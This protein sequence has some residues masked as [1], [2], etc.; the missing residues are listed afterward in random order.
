MLDMIDPVE[1]RIQN[2]SI[3]TYP[4]MST[5]HGTVHVAPSNEVGRFIP[6]LGASLPPS[7]WMCVRGVEKVGGSL[8]SVNLV[9]TSLSIARCVL[10]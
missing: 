4:H 10:C 3:H 8:R 5:K 9:R 7:V 6:S 2:T 1:C